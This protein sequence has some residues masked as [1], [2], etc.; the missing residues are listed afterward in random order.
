MRKFIVSVLSFL[1]I[2]GATRAMAGTTDAADSKTPDLKTAGREY[3]A[4][5][6][7]DAV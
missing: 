5:F 3:A 4:G 7:R 2:G 6:R 1:A